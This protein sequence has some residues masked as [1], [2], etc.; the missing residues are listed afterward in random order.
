MITGRIT[1]AA[2]HFTTGMFTTVAG[3]VD[4]VRQ[5]DQEA[6]DREPLLDAATS[7]TIPA[8][9]RGHSRVTPTRHEATEQRAEKPTSTREPSVAMTTAE[10]PEAIPHEAARALA[11]ELLMEAEAGTR[12]EDTTDE[13]W[14]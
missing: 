5:A 3:T 14:A 4:P 2:Q 10:N 6:T 8:H 1:R 11:G 9:R 13:P 7:T 12:A